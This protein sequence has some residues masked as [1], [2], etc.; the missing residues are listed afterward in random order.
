M[1]EHGLFMA[2]E[3]WVNVA[4][5]GEIALRAAAQQRVRL[6]ISSNY[7]NFLFI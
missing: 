1:P 6:S 2:L 7:S 5:A 3:V 4:L